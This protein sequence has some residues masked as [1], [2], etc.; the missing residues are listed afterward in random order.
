[1]SAILG[2]EA[3]RFDVEAQGL[4]QKAFYSS[5]VIFERFKKLY[6]SHPWDFQAA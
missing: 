4:L 1:M 5:S 2:V 6:Y 3:I